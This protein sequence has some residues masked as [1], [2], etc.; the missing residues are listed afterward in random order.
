MIIYRIT[1]NING[2][3]Y[4][5]QTKGLLYA[6]IASY[7]SNINRY[8]NK[9]RADK[10]PIIMAMIKYG[11]EN[12]EFEILED[13]IE[14]QLELDQ[15]EIHYIKKYN[16]QNTNIGYNIQNG[17]KSGGSGRHKKLSE[18]QSKEVIELYLALPIDQ[19]HT[20]DEI[21]KQ[22][23]V[24]FTCSRSTILRILHDNNIV[25]RKRIPTIQQRSTLAHI[26]RAR[27]K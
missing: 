20:I 12:F 11:F 1:N 2:K 23:A 6:R 27:A 17:G 10:Y 7:T 26:N 24:K 4:I 3:I 25:L 13:K 15:K 18:K 21:Y 8:K 5:G 22:L 9:K 19:L 16:S 14:T